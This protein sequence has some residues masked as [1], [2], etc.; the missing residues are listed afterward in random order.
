M[1]KGRTLIIYGKHV[2]E[3]YHLILEDRQQCFEEMVRVA[4]ALDKS[5][6]PD[7]MNYFIFGN[8]VAHL[9]WHLIPRYKDDPSWGGPVDFTL[10]KK[11][12]DEEYKELIE[13]IRRNL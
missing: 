12:K 7:K 11:L 6:H 5:F 1:F 10:K 3:L 4:E 8:V 13:N 2:T 9:H